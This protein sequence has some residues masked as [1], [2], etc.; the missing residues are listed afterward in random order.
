M[1]A[2]I[3]L[4]LLAQATPGLAASYTLEAGDYSWVETHGNASNGNPYPGSP[5]STLH[6]AFT[7]TD[8]TTWRIGDTYEFVLVPG[9]PPKTTEA[10]VMNSAQATVTI[11]DSVNDIIKFQTVYDSIESPGTVK[12]S[13]HIPGMIDISSLDA[14]IT[15][16]Q[17]FKFSGSQ[18]TWQSGDMAGSGTNES[19]GLSFTLSGILFQNDGDH[20]HNGGIT[21]FTLNYPAAAP[22]PI[23][24]AVWLLGTGLL[25]LG[26][27]GWRR[28]S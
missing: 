19:T 28:R 21:S 9:D 12:F 27:V 18:W 22:T 7:S 13:A 10:N 16:T 15:M 25:G 20:T 24:G 8:G 1:T 14:K 3:S 11:V 26:C 23:P 4:V 2:L 5:N 17:T 6:G